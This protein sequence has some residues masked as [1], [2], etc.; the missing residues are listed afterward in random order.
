M[1]F[2]GST[3][4]RIISLLGTSALNLV[5]VGIRFSVQVPFLDELPLRCFRKVSHGWINTQ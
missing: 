5:D 4:A 1:I 3:A 2:H